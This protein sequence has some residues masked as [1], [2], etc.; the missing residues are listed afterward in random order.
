MYR[1]FFLAKKVDD[2]KTLLIHKNVFSKRQIEVI[3][4]Y[5]KNKDR[6]SN[7]KR[8]MGMSFSK[9]YELQYIS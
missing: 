6:F 1:L 7:W 8:E 2:M 3:R 9:P 4:A 5:S